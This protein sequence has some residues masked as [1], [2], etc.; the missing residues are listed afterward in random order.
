MKLN[1]TGDPIAAYNERVKLLAGFVNAVALGLIGFAILRPLTESLQN[2]SLSTMW[3]GLAGLAL[4]GI[5]HYILGQIRKEV[6]A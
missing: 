6:S 3:W 2:A 1:T 5:A 4:H